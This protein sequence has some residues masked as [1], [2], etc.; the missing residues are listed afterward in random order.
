[1]FAM[2]TVL[3]LSLAGALL[4]GQGASAAPLFESNETIAL[5]IEAPMRELIRYRKQKNEYDAVVTWTEE[6][7]ATVSIPAKL[8]P[9]GN[10]RLATC[11]F[12][13]L[14]IEFASED[15]VGT[16]FEGQHRLKMVNP[17]GR[18]SDQKTWLSHE[19]SVYRGYNA[20]TDKSYRVRRLAV[21]YKDP[22]AGR[23]QRDLPAFFIEP[24]DGVAERIGMKPLR[25]VTVRFD[26][27]DIPETTL[28]M[29]FQFLI[30]NTD[31]SVLKGTSGEGCCHNGSLLSPPGREH[32][33]IVLPYDFD[34]AGF[35][36]TAYA[37]PDE[38]L[39]LRS[40]QVRRYRGFCWQNDALPQAIA[41]YNEHRDE[42]TAAMVPDDVSRSR[43][44]R[45]RG[46]VDSFYAAIN[47]EKELQRRFRDQCR[48]PDTFE[49]R[50]STTAGE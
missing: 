30:S 13:P 32:E 50:A 11:D 46:L 42:I 43:Q 38:R 8:K 28:H 4:V 23:W 37:L 20:I 41:H 3:A 27:L 44:R 22:T 6:S 15:T 45:A 29:L 24:V 21:T 17:C 14:R 16:V 1:M 26:Q 48:G 10:H 34:Q 49:I 2:K 35:V 47:D 12:P 40:V 18:G 19:Y 31:F 7:G 39:G 9:R 5:T 25:P 36:N 33:W